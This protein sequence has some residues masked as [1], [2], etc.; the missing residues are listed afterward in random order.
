MNK[1]LK[2]KINPVVK[3][4]SLAQLDMIFALKPGNWWVKLSIRF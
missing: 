3:T 4:S 2:R 1:I